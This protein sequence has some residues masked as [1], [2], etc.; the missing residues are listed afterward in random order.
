M[1][2]IYIIILCQSINSI[3]PLKQIFLS[4]I[5]NSELISL[6]RLA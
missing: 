5:L 2:Y 3:I 4:I 1:T 6:Q